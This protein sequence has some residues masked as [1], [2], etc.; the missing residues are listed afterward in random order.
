MVSVLM[1]LDA[2]QASQRSL[3]FTPARPPP[4]A[5]VQTIPQGYPGM[6][7]P[8]HAGP[9]PG[10][11]HHPPHLTL[12]DLE[13]EAS[14]ESPEREHTRR[15]EPHFAYIYTEATLSATITFSKYTDSDSKRAHSRRERG[16][17]YRSAS[18][19]A[20]HRKHIQS[21]MQEKCQDG[22]IKPVVLAALCAGLLYPL[23]HILLHLLFQAVPHSL[24][25]VLLSSTKI[26]NAAVLRWGLK[27]TKD[28]SPQQGRKT[29][30]PAIRLGGPGTKQ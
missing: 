16:L 3:P 5:G 22:H 10:M 24:L 9:P 28:N 14:L 23:I 2:Y 29:R 27:S 1:A 30:A 21:D 26:Q 18:A 4:R 15:E 25:H 12:A 11:Y 20:H 13:I 8:S 19:N 6:P 17:S 7:D